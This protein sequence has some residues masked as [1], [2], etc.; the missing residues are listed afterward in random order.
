MDASLHQD[1]EQPSPITPINAGA[2]LLPDHSQ[3]FQQGLILADQLAVS[4]E[5]SEEISALWADGDAA[6]DALALGVWEE[7]TVLQ[8]EEVPDIPA[9]EVGS[10]QPQNDAQSW[11]QVWVSRGMSKLQTGNLQGAL[12]NFIHALGKYPNLL[13]AIVGQGIVHYRL[14]KY[15]EAVHAF[16]RAIQ[17]HPHQSALYCHLGISLYRLGQVTEALIAY[18]QAVRL[19]PEDHHAYYCLGVALARE[20]H[21]ERAIAAFQGAITLT[22]HADS[23]YGLGYVHFLLNDFPAAIAAIG[24]AKQRDAKYRPIYEKFLKH[25]LKE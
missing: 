12:E 11:A 7:K 19:N 14:G 2:I 10:R 18:E 20:K 22:P 5:V 8:S 1:A 15:Q 24:K 6:V 3:L 23:Y 16:Q 13:E 9:P 21:Y 17:Q 4:N 25:C